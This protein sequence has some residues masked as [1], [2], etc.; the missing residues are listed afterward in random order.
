MSGISRIGDRTALLVLAGYDV[1]RVKHLVDRFEPAITLLGLQKQSVDS[2]NQIRMKAQQE[3]FKDN[4][5][6]VQFWVD[7]YSYDHGMSAVSAA[8]EPYHPNHNI[9]M[10]SMGPKLSAV[11]LYQLHRRDETLGLV[12][13]PSREFNL[14][15]S[16]G[17][18]DS[19]W[20]TLLGP[21]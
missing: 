12:Y 9:L 13:L 14:D 2:S 1:D 19:I 10:A 21:S 7:A 17:I 4:T 18:G 16:H 20:G 6:V 11:A 5:A 8:L 15:Y 3:A